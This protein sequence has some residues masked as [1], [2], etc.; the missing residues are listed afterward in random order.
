[1]SEAAIPLEPSAGSLQSVTRT[2]L[3]DQA[4][5]ALFHRIVTGEFPEGEA[6]P[7]EHELSA[8]F[9]I[10]RP[11][12]REALRR[13]RAEGLI[14]SQQGRGSFVQPR[15]AV[16]VSSRH[17]SDKIRPLLDNLEFRAAIEP[18]AAMLAAQRRTD[19]DL[20]AMRKAVDNYEQ[21]AV[22]NG[23]VGEHLDFAFHLAVAT[24]THNHRFIEAIKTVAYDIDHG[25]NL[26]RYLVRFE[27]L[28]RSRSVLSDHSRILDA[29]A[30][31]EPE[32]AAEA[33]R[34]H[35]RRARERMLE[36]RP[37]TPATGREE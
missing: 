31:R 25:V 20:D 21:V 10:S 35:L 26:A 22:V 8:Q 11:V 30:L 17:L 14:A 19:A 15:P 13:L 28:E 27:H 7:S 34:Q 5:A 1:M 9:S 16:D 18:Q 23:G 12:V 33:M 4:Y 32:A 29:I 6:L 37:R 36:S 24:A 2:K 3:A